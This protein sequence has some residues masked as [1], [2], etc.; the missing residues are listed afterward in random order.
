MRFGLFSMGEHPR[1]LPRD[2]YEEDLQEI[3]AADRFGWDEVWI[4]EHHL[5]GKQ[6]VLPHPEM[7]IAK[8][9]TR[10]E[11]IRLG[12][13]VRLLAL[14]YPLDVASEAATADHLTDGRYL[15]GY[16]TGTPLD[17]PFYGV[18]FADAQA[19]IDESLEL[20]ERAWAEDEPFSWEGRHWQVR[21]VY[22]WPR[23]LQQPHMP[24][25]RACGSP[26]SWYATG[27]RGHWV[28][29]SQY[30]TAPRLQE[31]WAHFERGARDAGRTPDRRDLHVC[32]FVWVG[33]S[34][35]TARDTIR[36]WLNAS[37]DYLRTQPPVRANLE[38]LKP[39]GG[40]VED[41]TF[42]YLAD[43]GQFVVGDAEAVARQLRELHADAGG[44]GT[45]LLVAGRDPAPLPERLAMLERFARDVAPALADLGVA[46]AL[47]A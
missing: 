19:R 38:R 31:G 20:I 18:A 21:D 28:L 12:P 8:A 17:F 23:P 44:F 39:E 29:A 47:P 5:N 45:F 26:D 30:Q 43:I 22:L 33:E 11:Q 10:T 37:L 35:R 46:A 41:V 14:H 3:V 34:E 27:R 6:E 16:G 32:R 13:G 40:T 36:P 25:A 9:A 24:M 4:G 2:A 15:F 7:L 42:D 1:R